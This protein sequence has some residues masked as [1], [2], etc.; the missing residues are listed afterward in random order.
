MPKA[1][2]V[3][4][5]LVSKSLRFRDKILVATRRIFG[6]HRRTLIAVPNLLVFGFLATAITVLVGLSWFQRNQADEARSAQVVLN[7]IAVL[8]R[9][10]NN[11]TLTALKTQNLNSEAEI[12]MGAARHVLP[13]AVLAA[14]LQKYHTSAVEKAWPV[15]DSYIM[16]SGRQWRLMQ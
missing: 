12:E 14:H 15:L 13:K 4:D 5:A 11:L 3:D 10:I 9:E 2:V 8:T 1:T 7:Q 6:L 16:S